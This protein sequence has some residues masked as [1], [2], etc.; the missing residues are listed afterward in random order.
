VSAQGFTWQSLGG[1]RIDVLTTRPGEDRFLV[2]LADR[3]A[4]VAE[5]RTGLRW[6]TKPRLRVYPTVAA[7]RDATG[8]PTGIFIDHA[9]E[10]IERAIPPASELEVEQAG[11]PAEAIE[12]SGGVRTFEKRKHAGQR[13]LVKFEIEPGIAIGQLGHD[14]VPHAVLGKTVLYGSNAEDVA[15]AMTNVEG[16]MTK[17]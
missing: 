17:E 16:R 3:L 14:V 7:F 11:E 5:Q 13:L 8:E 2:A 9:E 10:L 1:E 4:S 12:N 6:E 15:E